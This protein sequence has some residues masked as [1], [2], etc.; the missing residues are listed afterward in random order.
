MDQTTLTASF[1]IIA[2]ADAINRYSRDK[3]T[4]NET[5]LQHTGWIATWVLFA[6]ESLQQTADYCQI[7]Y[8]KL[9]RRAVCHDLD[10]IG[11][12]DIPRTT[13]YASPS[14]RSALGELEAQVPEWIEKSL[15]LDPGTVYHDWNEAKDVSREGLLIKFADLA[16][17]VYKCWDEIIRHSNYAFA[18][19]AQEIEGY[20]ATMDR[21]MIG[22]ELH[23]SERLWFL[24]L[25]RS[26]S[27]M[28]L[29]INAMVA[30]RKPLGIID[31]NI[32]G[33]K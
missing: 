5:V 10:E 18:R 1:G 31:M 24:N 21:S 27:E 4:V 2:Q 9:L 29:A 11:T 30:V 16:A 15:G 17:V 13:K 23:N 8:G 26:L 25:H 14:L 28:V 33:A 7:D 19:V 12:G 32:M 3:T 20:L 6:A 22:L